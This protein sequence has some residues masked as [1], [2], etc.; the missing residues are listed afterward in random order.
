MDPIQKNNRWEA[1][2]NMHK[3]PRLEPYKKYH[4]HNTLHK[5]YYQHANLL[6]KLHPKEGKSE[7]LSGLFPRNR[8]NTYRQTQSNLLNPG[9][10]TSH[11][12]RK[13]HLQ[14]HFLNRYPHRIRR[15][16]R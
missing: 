4:L 13:P 11:P 16:V 10:P 3:Y 15:G 7:L 1:H 2:L 8:H 14:N 6:H 12:I 5:G 9:K